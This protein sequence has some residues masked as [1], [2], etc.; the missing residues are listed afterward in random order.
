MEECEVYYKLNCSCKD[1]HCKEY[2][3][4]CVFAIPKEKCKECKEN[5]NKCVNCTKE[6]KIQDIQIN[7]DIENLQDEFADILYNLESSGKMKMEALDEIFSKS[8]E[9]ISKSY[10]L[11][12]E[13]RPK[14]RTKELNL[15][16]QNNFQSAIV[17]YLNKGR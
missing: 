14:I 9:I 12:R 7:K 6:D 2:K 10:W 16:L 15:K 11:G 4:Y 5:L 1:G 3:G 8:M 17:N 13:D